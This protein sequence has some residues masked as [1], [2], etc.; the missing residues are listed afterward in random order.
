MDGACCLCDGSS[1]QLRRV[2]AK[3]LKSLVLFAEK[4]QINKYL[5]NWRG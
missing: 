5:M 2:T 1:G 3:G 4:E